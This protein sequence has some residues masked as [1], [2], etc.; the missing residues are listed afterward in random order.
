MAAG[1]D[2]HDVI[3]VVVQAQSFADNVRVGSEFPPPEPVADHDLQ[4]VAGSGIVR[5]ECAAQLRVYSEDREVI[6]RNLLEAETQGLC[7]AGEVHVF[8]DAGNRRGLEY[9]RTLEVSPLRDGDADA[10]RAYAGKVV[11]DA[12]QLGR[13]WIRQRVQQRGVNHAIDRGSGSDAQ[14]HCGDRNERESRRSQKHANRVPQVE[15]QILDEGN[16]VLG[17]VLFADRFGRSEL[18]RGL[19]PR[20]G[21]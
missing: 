4:V 17:V 12:D 3:N 8:T 14:R 2:A 18:E 9:P 21:G 5:I 1:W 19:P 16:A 10:L 6:R 7:T 13:V 11:L 15:E 20:L